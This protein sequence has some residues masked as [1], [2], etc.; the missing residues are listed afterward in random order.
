MNGEI[1]I[2]KK[3]VRDIK[4]LIGHCSKCNR[5]KLMIVIINTVADE[6]SGDFFKS[7]DKNSV[8][9]GEKLTKNG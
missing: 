1:T 4:I 6:G 8:K 9:V 7:L 2:I 5:K 3:T